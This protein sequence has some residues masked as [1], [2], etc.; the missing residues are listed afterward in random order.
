MPS[1]SQSSWESVGPQLEFPVWSEEDLCKVLTLQTGLRVTLAITDNA[2]TLMSVRHKAPNL[3]TVRIHHMFLSADPVTLKALAR[4][5]KYPG[6]RAAG[7]TL[8]A[9]IAA[10]N[11]RVRGAKPRAPRIRTQGEHYDLQELYDEVNAAHFENRVDAPITWG[12][13]PTRRR[14]RSIRFGSY[15]LTE[16]LIRMHPNLDDA[17]VPRFFVRY[18]V[19]HEMLHADLG[20]QQSANGRNRMHTPEFNR[21][22]RE[23]PDYDRAV[24]WHNDLKNLR[25]LLRK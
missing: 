11:H 9:F 15:S 3:A 5:V 7:P 24:E 8:N 1:S 20:F 21:I 23:Y 17:S 12:K 19:F 4:W 18:I 13:R 10:N 6:S 22:E 16:H 2:S 14:R 25:R